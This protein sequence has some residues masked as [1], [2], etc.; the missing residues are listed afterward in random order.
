MLH[1]LE[2]AR[3]SLRPERAAELVTRFDWL[4]EFAICS[5]YLDE[6]L[7]RYRYL[8]HLAGMLTTDPTQLKPLAEAYAA[9]QEHQKRLFRF[10][11]AQKFSCYSTSLGEL[12]L[13]PELGNPV[14]L[15]KELYE[16]SRE[17]VQ[18]IAGPEA[19]RY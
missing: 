2:L 9:V 6:S 1:E 7:W 17:T 19:V 5:R 12:R 15:M 16:K 14:P 8:R 11:L 3:P 13:K 18:S 4:K 10:D